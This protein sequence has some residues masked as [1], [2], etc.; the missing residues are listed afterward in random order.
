[1]RHPFQPRPTFRELLTKMRHVMRA[2]DVRTTTLL[3]IALLIVRFEPSASALRGP[4]AEAAPTRVVVLGVDH[5]AQLVSPAN[6]PAALSAFI[7]KLAPSAICIERPPE[8]A[9]R[10]DFYEFTYEVQD[11]VLPLVASHPTDLCPIDWMPS[12]EDQKLVF[13]SDLDEPPEVRPKQGFQSFLVF[14]DPQALTSDIFFA[15]DSAA[16]ERARKFA[17]TPAV[18]ADQDFSRRL[19]LYRTF[20]QSQRIRA[21]ITAHAG[22]TVLVVVGYFHKPDLEAILSRDER[23]ELVQPSSVGHASPDAVHRA[24]TRAN[25]VAVLSFNLLGRQAATRNVNWAFVET[26]LRELEDESRRDPESRLFRAR[27]EELTGKMAPPQGS[28]PIARLWLAPRR[29]RRSRGPAS[30]TERALIR[31]SIRSAT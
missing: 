10:H 15:D 9:E 6:Q 4:T 28:T 5:A 22:H 16:T 8:Q 24:T 27:F 23:L 2:L 19:Y 14:P 11:I 17:A 26:T 7:E 29:T 1:M 30:R 25:R 21:A 12:V 13:G 20:M 31:I 3:A 18:R